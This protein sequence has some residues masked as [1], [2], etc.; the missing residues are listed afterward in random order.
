MDA[1]PTPI[2]Q[3]HHDRYIVAHATLGSLAALVLAPA[4]ILS[5][6]YLRTWRHWNVVHAILNAFTAILIIIVFALGLAALP[7]HNEFFGMGSDTHH[8]LGLATFLIVMVQAILGIGAR[9]VKHPPHNYV[10]LQKKRNPLRL[11]HIAFG[12]GTAGV[13]YAQVYTGFH[14]WDIASESMTTVPRSVWI[15]YWILFSIEVFAYAVGW[16]ISEPAGRKKR[17]AELNSGS[18]KEAPNGTGDHTGL[19]A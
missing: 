17:A 6:R 16:A 4:A 18:M 7:I 11:F 15:I 3:S 13:L 9:A 10:T 2:A 8:K 14:E 5:G 1:A 12:I 19:V